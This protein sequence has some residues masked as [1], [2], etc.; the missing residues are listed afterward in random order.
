[1]TVDS[2]LDCYDKIVDHT[3]FGHHCLLLVILPKGMFFSWFD[4]PLESLWFFVSIQNLLNTS[5]WTKFLARLNQI[6]YMIFIWFSFYYKL[7]HG[8]KGQLC[9]LCLEIFSKSTCGILNCTVLCFLWLEI[10]SK[11]T[12]GWNCTFVGY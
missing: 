2:E 7:E 10:F 1:M 6:Q 9:C 4:G 5:A 8:C 12:R 3:S 11:S